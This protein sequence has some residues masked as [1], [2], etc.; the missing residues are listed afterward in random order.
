MSLSLT[1]SHYFRQK[2]LVA[3]GFIP[4]ELSSAEEQTI[5][6]VNEHIAVKQL[7]A[8]IHRMVQLLDFMGTHEIRHRSRGEPTEN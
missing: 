6:G 5:N 2:G 1:D 3:Y 8:G 7:G 4:I